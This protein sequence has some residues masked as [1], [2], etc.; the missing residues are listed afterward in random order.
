MIEG[1]AT[2][3][4]GTL[5]DLLDDMGLPAEPTGSVSASAALAELRA[6]ER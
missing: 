6:G 3:A 1:R 5:I 2:E 4:E